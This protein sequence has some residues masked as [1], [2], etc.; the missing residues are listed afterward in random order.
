MSS[1]PL[2]DP[3]ALSADELKRLVARL[4]ARVAALEEE[5]RW[6]REENARLKDLPKR[7][8]LAPRRLDP[9]RRPGRREAP[10]EAAEA[11]ARR[12]GPGDR[13]GRAGGSAS[14]APDRPRRQARKR[15]SHSC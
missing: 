1:P 11:G 5:N 10:A 4:L 13:A 9:G 15:L 14:A 2:P 6:L 8:R 7:P 3:D 12:H